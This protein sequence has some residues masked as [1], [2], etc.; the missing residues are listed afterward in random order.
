M[1]DDV[2]GIRVD[3]HR[4]ASTYMPN[5][6]AVGTVPRNWAE[7]ATWVALIWACARE[8]QIKSV[9]YAG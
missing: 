8:T 1:G 6:W 2:G 4:L 5:D 7:V 3:G 9:G